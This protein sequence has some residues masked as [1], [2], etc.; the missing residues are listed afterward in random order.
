[1]LNFPSSS[2]VGDLDWIKE[3]TDLKALDIH[4][5][6]VSGEQKFREIFSYMSYLNSLSHLIV[7]FE[8]TPDFLSTL[9]FDLSIGIKQS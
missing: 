4:F 7:E 5:S 9:L 2:E 8:R 3:C 6:N 1:M